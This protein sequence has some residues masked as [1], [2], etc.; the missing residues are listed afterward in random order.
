[1]S[2]TTARLAL[3][4]LALRALRRE[5]RA[6]ELRVLT[7]ALVVAVAS[8][9]AVG[10][11]TD[12]M[13]RA[14]LRQASEL[15]A[16]DLVVRSRDPVEKRLAREARAMGLNTARTL[17]FR[18]VLVAGDQL[19]LTELK[20]VSP[21][22]PLR[23][24]LRVADA[25]Y[26]RDRAARG[27]PAP[28]TVWLDPRLMTVLGLAVGDRV[29]V[30]AARLEV[31]RVLA[32]EPDRGGDLFSIAP[33][34]LMRLADV[35][36]T[37]LV[38]PASRVSHRL[39]V[40]GPT[41]AVDAFAARV[42]AAAGAAGG[43][44]ELQG[45]R[46]ARPE[47]RAAL[48]RSKRFLGLAS[49]VT[50][51]LAGVAIALA[52]RRYTERHLDPAAVM[53][54][55]GASQREVAGSYAL[56][57]L[58]LGIAGSALG[59]VLGYAA[60]AALAG[61]VGSLFVAELPAPGGRPLLLGLVTGVVTLA[62]FGLAPVL[63]LR[64]V[65]PARVLR[66]DLGPAPAAAW[67]L[68]G[69]ALVVLTALV[70]WHAAD[71][72]LAGWV[73]A[74]CAAT[75]AVLA[76][77]AL[78]LVRAVARL[79]AGVGVA[80][81]FGLA[82][83]SRRASGSIVQVVGFGL[84][85]MAL[86]L[87]TLVRT[88]LLGEWRRSLPEDTPNFFLINV[89]SD[90]VGALKTFL[91]AHGLA[92]ASLHPMVRA[93]LERIDGRPASASDYESPRA[94]RLATRQFNLSWSRTL[95]P[96]NEIVAGRWWYGDATVGAPDGANELSL[97][98]GIAEALGVGVGDRLTFRIAGEPVSGEVTSLRAVEW[99]SFNVNFFVEATPSMLEGR[100]ATWITSFHL[101]RERRGLLADLVRRFPSVTVI[102]V[103]ALLSRVR[104]IMDRAVLA[105]EFIFLFSVAAGV[106]VLLAAVQA[107]LDERRYESA[108]MR[109]LG[110][111]RRRVR[112]GLL[113]EF[114]TLGV[115]SGTLGALAAS[116]VGWVLA[117]EVFE[118]SWRL[119]PWL[120]A[121]GLVGGTAG[122]AAAGLAGTRT[123]LAEPPMRSLRAG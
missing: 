94:R 83:L 35:P 51:L 79:R 29:E 10:F 28:G 33:R 62:G 42:H 112:A 20:A 14:M 97:E 3:L 32:Y 65:P 109:T 106:T 13:D 52:V 36:A 102:D 110:A 43:G 72:R 86:L 16:A 12:R 73:L 96:D 77:A 99:D 21:G 71:V 38:Q 18:S 2:T 101:E 66:R 75:V 26:A 55:L 107:T 31:A 60:Q 111:D 67:S 80:W 22:Y 50:V 104:A 63:R 82:N 23:G 76:A 53:R 78:G 44:L 9:T 122:V 5:A 118:L 45:L 81:R 100:P 27:V 93:R 120:W 61:L 34:L 57:L 46:D 54:C 91:A 114:L 87:L 58:L 39:L 69:A 119:N 68:P 85:I 1:M 8:T 117:T 4:R 64:H 121:A 92:A 15:L 70:L 48:D 25:P 98:Q 11:F 37:G 19:Q 56:Q 17:S 108:V 115:L 30:G 40:A 47:M 41:D 113:A 95:K 103:D 24:R 84:G 116:A 7:A 89:Q 123:V 6:G 90:E 49:V 88:D 105:V 74:G 59:C